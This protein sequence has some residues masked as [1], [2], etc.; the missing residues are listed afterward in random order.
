M[1]LLDHHQEMLN[2]GGCETQFNLKRALMTG[3][4][5]LSSFDAEDLRDTATGTCGSAH[6]FLLQ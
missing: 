3:L 4:L 5:S 1:Q 6:A 2:V